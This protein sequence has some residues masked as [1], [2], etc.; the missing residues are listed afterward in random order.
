MDWRVCAFTDTYLPTVNGVT[1]TVKSWRDAWRGAGGRMDVVYPAAE[2]HDPGPGEHPVPSV[3]FPFYD[4]YRLGAPLLPRSLD[5]VDIVHA[6]TPFT[7]GVAAWQLARQTGRPFVISYHTPMEEYTP[8][9]AGVEPVARALSAV[10]RSYQRWF[11]D[12][13]DVVIA[14]TETASADLRRRAGFSGE[15]EIVSNGVDLETF[16]PRGTDTFRRRQDLPEGP[17]I[18]YTGRHGYEKRLTNLIE[19]AAYGSDDWTVVF[20]GRGPATGALVEL[21]E[22]HDVDARFLGFL[23]REELP[24]FYAALDVFAF[25]SPVETQGL[26]ALE[27]MACGTPVVG[28]DAGALSETIEHGET[29]LLYPRG[30]LQGFAD[31]L[32]RALAT[33][34]HLSATCLERRDRLGLGHSMDQLEGVYSTVTG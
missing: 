29:G 28:V 23:D 12:H 21:A 5:G 16:A 26:V 6:H 3:P 20:G 34:D 17:I 27:A 22:E 32:E 15:V 25:P 31:A 13:A 2:G 18:G 30:D 10:S 24:S 1:Y 7:L 9:L 4:G 8:Y 14:P 11:F 33:N 19:A